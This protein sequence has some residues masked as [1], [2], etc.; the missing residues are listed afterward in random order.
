VHD[1]SPYNVARPKQTSDGGTESS[2]IKE[3]N[4][5]LDATPF[6]SL[7]DP[8]TQRALKNR[9]NKSKKVLEGSR[10]YINNFEIRNNMIRTINLL[11]QDVKRSTHDTSLRIKKHEQKIESL[12]QE[13]RLPEINIEGSKKRINELNKQISIT[14]TSTLL[15]QEQKKASIASLHSQI[16]HEED[17]I[18]KSLAN[19]PI[20]E[21]R[22]QREQ[23]LLEQ[24]RNDEAQLAVSNVEIQAICQ[25]LKKSSLPPQT[26]DTTFQVSSNQPDTS[27]SR[28]TDKTREVPQH[29]EPTSHFGNQAIAEIFPKV[30]LNRI[31]NPTKRNAYEYVLHSYSRILHDKAMQTFQSDPACQHILDH[32][33]ASQIYYKWYGSREGLTELIAMRDIRDRTISVGPSKESLRNLGITLTDQTKHLYEDV[34]IQEVSEHL[35]RGGSVQWAVYKILRPVYKQTEEYQ[36][37]IGSVGLYL[38]DNHV[39]LTRD[40]GGS[41]TGISGLFNTNRSENHTGPW[42]RPEGAVKVQPH[43]KRGR[44]SI[45]GNVER[46]Q[47]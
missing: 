33:N 11:E 7:L 22:A 26:S 23:E 30:D 15:N 25:Q 6:N 34:D 8:E 3:F 18:K 19:I 14:G 32:Y 43:A 24:A 1:A 5:R 9:I 13:R 21:N 37:C 36:N 35:Q 10:K 2:S 40:F 20:I 44:K 39:L 41:N 46:W 17:K 29:P 4:R 28:D 47:T 16:S 31:S 38:T 45:Y 42:T 27:P 12:G